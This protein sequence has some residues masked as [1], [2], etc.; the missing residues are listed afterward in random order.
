MQ[1]TRIKICGIT[2]I[3]DALAVAAAGADAIGLVFTPRS[4]RYVTLRKA[5]AICQALPPFV[6]RVGLFMDQDVEA[7]RAITDH[8]WLD[9]LQFHGQ[10][11]VAYCEQFQHSYIK[12]LAMGG[13]NAQ[14]VRD[15][16][17]PW[18]SASALLLDAHRPGEVGGQGEVFDWSLIPHDPIRPMVLAGG[19]RPTNVAQAVREVRPYAVDVS[20]G[21]ESA[22]GIKD[23]ALLQPFVEEVRRGD[24]G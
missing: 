6:A 10:E 15:L 17:A 1:R 22:P 12:A 5:Q 20:S 16:C 14:Q 11:S 7:V 2:R 9:S 3:E 4:K 23:P 21:V 13:R 19:L 24:T 18:Q 8:V